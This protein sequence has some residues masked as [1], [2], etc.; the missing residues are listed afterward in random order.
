MKKK[1]RMKKWLISISCFLVIVLMGAYFGINYAADRVMDK[2]SDSI[3]ESAMSSSTPSAVEEK[4]ST[5]V[6]SDVLS[7]PSNPA[8][9]VEPTNID[10]SE[11]STY[12]TAEP[13]AASSASTNVTSGDKD[14][15]G[16]AGAAPSHSY[17]A[18]VSVDKAE[19]VKEEITFSEK[20]KLMTIML[21]R[22]DASDI[23]TLSDLAG[24][25]LSLEKKREAKK[26]IL[27]K[28]SEKEYNELIK[29]AQKYGLSE[30]KSYEDSKQ[31]KGMQE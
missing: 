22:L 5:P 8:K 28:L 31:E 15:S 1:N 10:Q 27:E 2:L 9:D 6:S 29:I 24:G 21:K 23:K 4:Q 19:T 13:S 11:P 14:S 30:G 16:T 17:S 7:S 12:S 3:L 26:I 25:G 20:T 18:E